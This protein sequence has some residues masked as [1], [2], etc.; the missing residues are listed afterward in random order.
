MKKKYLADV[1]N[2]INI[3]KIQP[4]F[5]DILPLAK[6]QNCD[7]YKS[8]K[9]WHEIEDD[10]VIYIPDIDLNQCWKF[11][12]LSESEMIEDYDFNSGWNRYV[13]EF[14]RNCYTKADFE[15]IAGDKAE[16]LF[17]FVD[18]QHPAS[19]WEEPWWDDEE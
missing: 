9:A 15:E 10:D 1:L 16:E 12:Q 2:V 5:H 19:A 3:E 8:D 4:F 18:W 11:W 17:D 7:I 6:G 13:K 14:L